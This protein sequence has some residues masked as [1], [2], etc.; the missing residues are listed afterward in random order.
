M[1]PPL[2]SIQVDP[3]ITLTPVVCQCYSFCHQ[4]SNHFAIV[5]LYIENV[6][7][8]QKFLF[9][10]FSFRLVFLANHLSLLKKI[11]RP[12]ENENCITYN[13]IFSSRNSSS[14]CGFDFR[15]FFFLD[16]VMSSTCFLSMPECLA[17]FTQETF[18]TNGFH[19]LKANNQRFT[20]ASS[21]CRQN[22]R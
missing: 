12:A 17:E 11:T 16:S 4:W 21:R 20:A 8:V 14:K 13:G 10:T 7:Y 15:C 3:R 22:L 9:F 18:V 19:V 6:V 1:F 5:S 2:D